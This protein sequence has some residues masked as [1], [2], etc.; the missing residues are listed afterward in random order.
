[1]AQTTQLQ[2]DFWFKNT[3]KILFWCCLIGY[4]LFYTPYGLENGD[5]GSIFGISWSMYNGYFPHLDFYYIKP[6]LPPYFHSLLLYLTEDHAYLL[7][8]GFYFVQVFSFSFLAVKLVSKLWLNL[9]S[10]ERYFLS[11]LAAVVTIHNYPPMPWNTIDGVFFGVIGLYILLSYQRWYQIALAAFFIAL[12]VLSKQSFYFFPVMIAGYLALQKDFKKLLILIGFGLFFAGCFAGLL[13]SQG[14][15]DAFYAQ[16]FSFTSGSSLYKA[17][18]KSYALAFKSQALWLIPLGGILYFF[19]KRIPVQASYV[20]LNL[21]IVGYLIYLFFNPDSYH[22]VK[23]WLYQ[24]WFLLAVLFGL[25]MWRKDK[26]FSLLLLLL[27]L[28]W[29]ASISNGFKTPVHFA[30]PMVIATYVLL[31]KL[32]KVE[33]S[34]GSAAAVLLAFVV[35]FSI[36]YQTVYNDSD[37]SELTYSMGD[38]FPRLAGIKSDAETHQQYQEL[39]TLSQ[40]YDNFTVV[41]SM[42]LAHYVT[43]TKNPIGVDWVFDHHLAGEIEKHY[44]I[45]VDKKVT[46]FLEPFEDHPNNYEESARLSVLIKERWTLVD[47]TPYFRV[48]QPPNL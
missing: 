25:L 38:V 30:V 42:T 43:D 46:V 8:R 40:Q 26:G 44:Q 27:G 2:S 37:R 3:F 45:L 16:T 13:L 10:E 19:R 1:M 7:N 17:G 35:C 24:V 34:K 12:S 9:S 23:A 20:V 15:W 29:C 14:A 31:I 48:Y 36:G 47:Q 32:P 4:L 21:A 11:A 5:M 39:K 41:P 33:L 6:A 18:F 22:S 28:S